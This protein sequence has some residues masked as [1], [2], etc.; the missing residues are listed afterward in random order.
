MGHDWTHRTAGLREGPCIPAWAR[1]DLRKAGLT[2]AWCWASAYVH[3]CDACVHA[4][5]GLVGSTCLF[6]GCGSKGEL[7]FCDVCVYVGHGRFRCS[8]ETVEFR[9]MKCL[10]TTVSHGF[11]F[12]TPV[13]FSSSC[14]W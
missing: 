2:S 13:Y 6:T 7:S 10:S 14:S 3:T 5:Q 12:L 11:P 9:L 4:L 8:I 1:C